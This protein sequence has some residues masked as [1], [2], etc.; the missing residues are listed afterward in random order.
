MNLVTRHEALGHVMGLTWIDKL[1]R[2][3]KCRTGP[4]KTRFKSP[5]LCKVCAVLLLTFSICHRM[6]LKTVSY[7]KQSVLIMFVIKKLMFSL[8]SCCHCCFL[9]SLS[10]CSSLL[11]PCLRLSL[12]SCC[13]AYS[14][15]PCDAEAS[16]TLC[17]CLWEKERADSDK[18]R[19]RTFFFSLCIAPLLPPTVINHT[20]SGVY[21]H[22]YC[23]QFMG[24]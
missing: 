18:E 22:L 15:V 21:Q 17:V 3:K 12:V 8:S 5:S 23:Y 7:N 10:F 9:F 2:V 20:L 11:T 1:Q 6:V 13:L 4:F 14:N 16:S 19:G 24:V